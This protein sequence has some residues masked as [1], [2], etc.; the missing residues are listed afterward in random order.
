MKGSVRALAIV[1]ATVAAAE[2]SASEPGLHAVRYIMGTWCDL[3]VFDEHPGPEVAESAF[4]EIARL[5]DVLSSW[6]P[7]SEVSRLNAS[8]GRGPQPVSVDLATIAE[9]STALCAT[10][11][12]AFDPSVAPLLK[13]WGFYTESPSVPAPETS[14]AAAAH[15]GCDRVSVQQ[16]PQSI[17]LA[18]GAALDFGGIGKGYAVD[19]ALA[20]LRARGITR[21]KLDF[22]S[23]SLGFLGRIDGG[24]P[25]VIADPRDRD[26]PLVSFR[27]AEGAVSTSSQRERFFERD[28]RRYGHI[29]DPRAGRPVESRLLS[30]TVIASQGSTADGLSTALFVLGTT[31]GKR[32]MSRMPAVSAV[33][34]EQNAGG[35]VAITTAGTVAGLTRLSH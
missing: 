15:V 28:G 5:E 23:S 11:G 25:V 22:G 12:G 31:Q 27:I 9:E 14:R 6:D 7:A 10:T 1:L 32:V 13:A 4:R 20:I 35:G 8:A 30:V 33:F 2:A 26:E 34:V 19:R 21:A 16:D 29:F 18:D 24:W 17:A 3:V